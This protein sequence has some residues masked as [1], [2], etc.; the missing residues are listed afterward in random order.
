MI[1]VS[2]VP[3]SVRRTATRI[4][5]R[6]P[7]QQ[8]DTHEELAEQ[9]LLPTMPHSYDKLDAI[10]VPASRPAANLDHA[11]TLARSARCQLLIL[12]SLEARTIEVEQLLISRSFNKAIVVNVRRD[13]IH[14][15][16]DFATSD[17]P[18]GVL[19][20][21]CANY[22]TDLS[23]KRNIGLLLA[24]M[25]GWKRI[26]FLDDDVRDISDTDLHTT[27]SMLQ[28]CDS[29]GIEIGSVADN[30]AVCHALRETGRYQDVFVSGAALAV[31]C[32]APMNFFPRIYNEDWLFLY[33]NAADRR[34]AL[35]RSNATQ[36]SYDPFNGRDRIAWQEFGDVLAEGLYGLIH[37]YRLVAHAN[38]DYWANFLRA[39][40]DLLKTII[41]RSD[42]ARAEIRQKMVAAVENALEYSRQIEPEMCEAY[43]R[44]WRYDLNRWRGQLKRIPRVS[45]PTEALRELGLPW[46]TSGDT[47]GRMGAPYRELSSNWRPRSSLSLR[48]SPQMYAEDARIVAASQSDAETGQAKTMP[49]PSL[50]GF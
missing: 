37:D 28:R 17:P 31:N 49:F 6:T 14:P 23:M 22:N 21:K 12:C 42:R 32:T 25:L 10:I 47:L 8:Y 50:A 36:L 38:R 7:A 18:N 41:Y 34:L 19:P 46:S 24:H 20:Q 35:T 5:H 33:N 3:S 43:I 26:F 27:V 44:L 29:V 30:S 9:V 40:R 13:Y 15:W 11:I 45:D 48:S 1:S 39:R 4:Q 2:G 16:L